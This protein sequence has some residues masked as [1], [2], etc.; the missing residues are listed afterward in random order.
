[1]EVSQSCC[2]WCH[3]PPTLFNDGPVSFTPPS[4]HLSSQ[5]RMCTLLSSMSVPLPSTQA[6]KIAMTW[7]TGKLQ[8]YQLKLFNRI[9]WA[10]GGHVCVYRDVFI[11]QTCMLPPLVLAGVSPQASLLPCWCETGFVLFQNFVLW[12]CCLA[13][14]LIYH[15]ICDWGLPILTQK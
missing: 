4:N 15:L 3:I 14:F 11:L 1:M 8:T 5:S 7:I 12:N 6:L 13:L 9:M 2:K 10:A